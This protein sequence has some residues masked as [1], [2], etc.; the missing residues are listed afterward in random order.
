MRV[1]IQY[2]DMTQS[3]HYQICCNRCGKKIGFGCGQ[4]GDV[5]SIDICRKC[6]VDMYKKELMEV[7]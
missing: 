1:A 3:Y 6:S 5:S 7:K 2:N 4:K